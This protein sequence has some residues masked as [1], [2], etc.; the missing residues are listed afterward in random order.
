[1]AKA[2]PTQYIQD[3]KLMSKLKNVRD[4][5]KYYTYQVSDI[6]QSTRLEEQNREPVLSIFEKITALIQDIDELLPKIK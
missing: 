5:L 2:T 6:S 4:G 1:M 3:S